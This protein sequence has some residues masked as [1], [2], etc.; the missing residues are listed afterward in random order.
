MAQPARRKSFTAS[1]AATT[2]EPRGRHTEG[3]QVDYCLRKTGQGEWEGEEEGRPQRRMTAAGQT[4][5]VAPINWI[6]VPI[7]PD[8]VA[9]QSPPVHG[10][11]SSSSSSS[12]QSIY[13]GCGVQSERERGSHLFPHIGRDLYSGYYY[14]YYAPAKCGIFFTAFVGHV[15]W[16]RAHS[17]V[18]QSV[19]QTTREK[20]LSG[21][22]EGEA[23]VVYT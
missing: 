21:R 8:L 7:H 5:D 22:W 16:R 4:Y 15:C 23:E 11:K 20:K 10:P 19:G 12:L 13:H 14:Y 2:C 9:T 18:S 17:S 3:D 6:T 1:A